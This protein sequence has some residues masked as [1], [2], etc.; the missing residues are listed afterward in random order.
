M[1]DNLHKGASPQLFHYARLNRKIQTEAEK[2]LW[3]CLKNR[4]LKGFKFR[5]QH[6]IAHFIADFF[7]LESNL[8]IEID[9]SYHNERGQREY[10]E[11]RTF[12]L[13]E[14]N[15]KVIRFTNEEVIENTEFVLR[16]ISKHL[17]QPH[18]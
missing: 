5:R 3:D 8:V 13:D 18:P 14:L 15:V 4:K 12:E 7:C 17:S 2:I 6:P 16:E 1:A 11:G 10:D 9:G